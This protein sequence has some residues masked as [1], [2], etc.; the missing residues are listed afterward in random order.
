MKEKSFLP[1]IALSAVLS[2]SLVQGA[3][4]S[5]QSQLAG[6]ITYVVAADGSGNYTT[7]QAAINAI[8]DTSAATTVIFIKNGTYNERDV[9]P[10]TKT[11]AVLIGAN[12]DSCIITGN[13]VSA[14]TYASNTFNTYTFR[15]DADNF[16]AMNLT[17]QNTATS[18]QAVALHANGDRQIFL[19]CRIIGYQD[20]YFNNIRTRHYF[21]DCFIQG[22]VDYIF[23]FGIELFDSCVMNSTG[24]GG[25]MTAA[26][27]SDYYKFGFV[28]RNCE[29]TSSSGISIYLGRP[30]FAY[31]R[32]VVMTTAEP[33]T[34]DAAGWSAWDGRED[35]C[36]YAEYNCTGPGFKPASRATFGHQLTAAQAQSYV[37]DT[38]FSHLSFPQG[39]AEDS[40]E[41]AFILHRWLVSTTPD[42]EQ[43]ADT[44]L[45]CGRDSIPPVP[46]TDWFP[47][48]D[49]DTNS[50]Y[51]VIKANTVMFMDTGKVTGIRTGGN[52]DSFAGSC[53][54]FESVTND[55][56]SFSV[57]EHSAGKITLCIFD[58]A[59]RAVFSKTFSI[60]AGNG[61]V[62][63]CN[64]GSLKPGAY[65]YKVSAGEMAIDG[66][67]GLIR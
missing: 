36:Y 1:L 50:I 42:M 23:G 25:C 12:V 21:K 53:V 26:S 6:K 56:I 55:R 49:V 41:I 46:T 31:A 47:V 14:N 67:F 10:W 17:I 44:L 64:V 57:N 58:V 32:T 35:T 45:K 11:N 61:N 33:A 24:S 13:D 37:P 39:H 65:L 38:I 2:A 9:V 62:L 29:L 27:T 34:L 8:P 59:G 15:V 51:A 16:M 22:G 60:A 19:H 40:A 52:D 20:T 43:I 18:A 30:W 4:S 5:L 3:T 28:F 66:K 63:S 48:A 54:R 7:V